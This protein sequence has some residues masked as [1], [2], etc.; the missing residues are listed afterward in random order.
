MIGAIFRDFDAI[1]IYH[2]SCS[3]RETL[4]AMPCLCNF[5]TSAIIHKKLPQVLKW[6]EPR[7]Y[8]MALINN[9]WQAL[10]RSIMFAGSALSSKVAQRSCFSIIT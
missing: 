9:E 2:G 7:S 5:E 1:G 4:F 6:V 3:T 8:K 10:A